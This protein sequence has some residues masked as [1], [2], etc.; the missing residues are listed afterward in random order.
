MTKKKK[1]NEIETRATVGEGRYEVLDE[2]DGNP[3][4]DLPEKKLKAPSNYIFQL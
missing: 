3:V 2:D 4:A 1:D